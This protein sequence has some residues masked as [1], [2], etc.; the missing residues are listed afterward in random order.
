MPPPLFNLAYCPIVPALEVIGGKWKPLVVYHIY[1]GARRFGSLQ[2][3]IPSIS[4]T[5]L[6]QQLR[7]LERDGLLH[8]QV[9]AEVPSRVE[10]TLTEIGLSLLPVLQAIGNW[11]RQLRETPQ[12]HSQP[13]VLAG[14]EQPL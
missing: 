9:F 6:T 4:K 5:M 11:G 13:A 2:R 3:D 8:R 10:Y 12:V 7:E 14:H 1:L